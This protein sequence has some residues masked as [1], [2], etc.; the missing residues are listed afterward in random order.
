MSH[1][2]NPALA[3][4]WMGSGRNGV[5]SKNASATPL[6]ALEV[7]TSVG[8][9]SLGGRAG[10]RISGIGMPYLQERSVRRTPIPLSVVAA[11]LCGGWGNRAQEFAHILALSVNEALKLD[12]SNLILLQ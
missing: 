12:H 5:Q 3:A 1:F 6:R 9:A 4:Q 11:S 2:K 7:W 8:A 10:Q